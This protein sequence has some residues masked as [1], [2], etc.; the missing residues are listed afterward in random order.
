M[1]I[2]RRLVEFIEG[3]VKTIE[4]DRETANLHQEY[5]FAL[6]NAL[7]TIKTKLNSEKQSFN[8]PLRD[9]GDLLQQMNRVIIDMC[10]VFI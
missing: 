2:L 9:I 8:F 4:Y 7:N 10:K 3:E 5:N 1:N 6:W